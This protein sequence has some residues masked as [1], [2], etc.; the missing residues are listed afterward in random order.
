MNHHQVIS[1]DTLSS[2]KKS[3]LTIKKTDWH[4][5]F[6]GIANTV[7]SRSTCKRRSVG[8][9]AV[10]LRRIIATG[11][12]GAPT[13]FA[14]CTDIGCLR[15][16]LKVPSGTRHELCRAVH[17][18]QNLIT[19]A[20]RFGSELF[21]ADV[22]CTHKPCAIC[23]KMLINAGVYHVYFQHDYPDEL[24][25]QLELEYARTH[26]GNSFLTQ[27]ILQDEESPVEAGILPERGA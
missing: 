12:N 8:A 23:L 15:E 4:G 25:D 6:I 19:Q 5:F 9:V 20:A 14:H 21:G 10:K 7:A 16:E 22:Y 17:A 27:I 13:G 18:E 24:T 3:R 2:P 1:I 26:H 11:F